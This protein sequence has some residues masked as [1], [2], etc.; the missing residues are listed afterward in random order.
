MELIKFAKIL[1]NMYWFLICSALILGCGSKKNDKINNNQIVTEDSSDTVDLED[2]VTPGALEDLNGSPTLVEDSQQN[3][4]VDPKLDS[5]PNH[6]EASAEEQGATTEGDGKALNLVAAPATKII[7]IM[8]EPSDLAPTTGMVFTSVD[9]NYRI[10]ELHYWN[11][12]DDKVTL[13]SSGES[14]DPYLMG[15]SQI[16]ALF[17]RSPGNTNFRLLKKNGTSFSLSPQKSDALLTYYDPHDAT[18]LDDQHLA[19]SMYTAGKIV[20]LNVETGSM[21]AVDTKSLDLGETKN[22]QFR[23]EQGAS[24][25]MGGKIYLAIAHQGWD[26]ESLPRINN[27][28]ALFLF[29]WE[30]DQLTPLDADPAKE[31]IQ[32]ILLT[33]TFPTK[34]QWNLRGELLSLGLCTDPAWEFYPEDMKSC[35]A[36]LDVIN[37][38]QFKLAMSFP[39]QKYPYSANP[40]SVVLDPER[41]E[42]YTMFLNEKTADNLSEYFVAKVAINPLDGEETMGKLYDF[43][44]NLALY[45]FPSFNIDLTNEQ[46]FV[47]ERFADGTSQIKIIKNGAII[48]TLP[49]RLTF[50]GS[51]FTQ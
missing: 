38:E 14:G 8:P 15:H 33:S 39:L 3:T 34:L 7:P 6:A 50:F 4:R 40:Y 17:N 37:V 13:I 51:Y 49:T 25:K 35:R 22:I 30:A 46:L 26:N 2:Q 48:K 28:Q 21:V 1:T 16:G 32:G 18:A 11:F 5:S 47:G 41:L 45:Y 36:A 24:F 23:P 42:F 29:V 43:P 44:V 9:M 31:G 19:L 27:S 12:T 10:S 20:V